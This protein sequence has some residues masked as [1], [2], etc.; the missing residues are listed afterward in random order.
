MDLNYEIEPKLKDETYGYVEIKAEYLK[1][2]TLANYEDRP[3]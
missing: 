3:C 1:E 2:N